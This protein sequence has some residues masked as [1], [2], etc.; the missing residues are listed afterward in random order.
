MDIP[1]R[2]SRMKEI[3]YD[4]W[5]SWQPETQ[6]LFCILDKHLWEE[7]KHNPIKFLLEL[8]PKKLE[9]GAVDPVFLTL[10]DRLINK[11]DN[12][13]RKPSWYEKNLLSNPILIAYFSAELGIHQSL[14]FYGGGLGVLAGDHCKSAGDLGIPLVGLSI[15]YKNGYFAQRINKDGWQEAIYPMINFR[16]IP[17]I[18]CTEPNGTPLIVPVQIREKQVYVQIWCQ[19]IGKVS[20]YLLD[21]DIPP[22]NEEDRKLTQRLYGGD[23]NT[24]I[25]QEIILGIGG[26][27]ALKALG[28]V[29][30]VWHIN[31]GHAAFLIIERIRELIRQGIPFSDAPKAVKANTIFTTHTPVPAG[32]DVFHKE[33]VLNYL[34]HIIN[35]FAITPEEFLSLGWDHEREVFN[36][37][38]LALFHSAYSNG[39]SRIHAQ[40]SKKIFSSMYPNILPEKVPISSI[41]NGIHL[42]SW[43]APKMSSLFQKYI[44]NEWVDY[45]TDRQ[46]WKKVWQIPDKELW[47]THQMLKKDMIDFVRSNVYHRMKKNREPVVKIKDSINKLSTNML[48]IGFARRF[49]TYKRADLLLNDLDRLSQLLNHPTKPVIFIFAGKAH[50]ADQPGQRIIKRIL[51]LEKDKRFQGRIIFVENYDLHTAQY[52]LPGVDLWLNTPRQPLEASGTS[53]Q[54]AA[55]NGVINCS[56][57]D[58]WWPEAANGENGFTIGRVR[59]SLDDNIQDNEDRLSLFELL[60]QV[61]IPCYYQQTGGYPEK[62][63]YH[64]KQSL[65]TI[66]WYFNSERMVKEYYERFYLPVSLK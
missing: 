52:L 39:V 56:I 18:L 42:P 47:Q 66:P 23:E 5:F 1:Q 33:M 10:Y 58:G 43:V 54:K 65:S 2:I 7:T 24:R 17:M 14:P 60:E 63:V 49:A 29:P 26:V 16:E 13:L 11:Y 6:E 37:T 55:V 30:T 51:D 25:A 57:Y 22:N 28:L 27:K 62:W 8:Y 59:Y 3:A 40:V 61:I 32:H 15:L 46:L 44:T 53:G 19:K 34:G 50:P 45:S 38:K 41:T 48:T 4:L 35:Q 31:E 64:M 20:I 36:M 9:Q 12:Y 21:A